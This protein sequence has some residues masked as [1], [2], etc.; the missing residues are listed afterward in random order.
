MAK[1][2]QQECYEKALSSSLSRVIDFVKFAEAKNAALLT[3]CSAWLLATINTLNNLSRP[4]PSVWVW[5]GNAAVCLFAVAAVVA[6]RSFLPKRL[7]DIYNDPDGDKSLIYFGHISLY[8][9]TRF[10]SLYK[11]RYMPTAG[12]VATEQYMSDIAVQISIN[13]AIAANKF[14]LFNIGAYIA[15]AGVIAFSIASL[16]PALM[17]VWAYLKAIS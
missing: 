13:S 12:Q 10:V 7:E 8:E 15:M 3:F 1:D 2:D 6:I 5:C 17:A 4:L 11:E 14:K 16:S 9:T